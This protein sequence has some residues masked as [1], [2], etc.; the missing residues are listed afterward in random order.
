MRQSSNYREDELAQ[1]QQ[2]RLAR[3]QMQRHHVELTEARRH[4]A[5]VQ[6]E[7]VLGFC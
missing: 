1:G 5:Q 6:R 2:L 4:L 7:K 3:E